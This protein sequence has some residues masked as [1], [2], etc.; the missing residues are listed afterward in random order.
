MGFV[1]EGYFI[2]AEKHEFKN[3][4]GSIDVRWNVNVAT[5]SLAYRVYMA[6]DFD[7]GITSDLKPGD[8]IALS[9]RCYVGKNGKL[10]LVDGKMI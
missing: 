5:G 9:I 10:S 6:A 3:D 1:L 2:G 8:M 7:P 4:D